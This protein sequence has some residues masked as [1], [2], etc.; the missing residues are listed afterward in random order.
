M[1]RR[2]NCSRMKISHSGVR[3]LRWG[4]FW[5]NLLSGLMFSC[6]GRV[7]KIRENCWRKNLFAITI[8]CSV[9]MD[10]LMIWVKWLIKLRMVLCSCSRDCS[11]HKL[12]SPFKRAEK[13]L[14]KWA[15]NLSQPINRQRLSTSKVT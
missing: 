8:L 10:S 4:R 1:R 7:Y 12:L 9:K 5:W 6:L 3:S 2:R 11:K 14:W 13:A 15:K